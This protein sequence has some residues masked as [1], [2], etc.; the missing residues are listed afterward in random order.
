MSARRQRQPD[1]MML[2]LLWGALWGVALGMWLLAPRIVAEHHVRFESLDQRILFMLALAAMFAVLGGFLLLISGFVL[3]IIDSRFGPFVDRRWAYALGGAVLLVVVYALNSFLIYWITFRRLE[4]FWLPSRLLAAGKIVGIAVA[5][6]AIA[7][8]AAMR[9]YKWITG[10]PTL[11]ST[12]A[13]AFGLVGVAVVGAAVASTAGSDGSSSQPAETL[14]PI[15][16]QNDAPPLLFL[17]IDGASWRVLMPEMENGSAPTLRRLVDAGNSGTMEAL[18]PPH[19]SGAAWGAILTGLPREVTG[20]YEDLA[21]H[22]NGLPPFQIHL[23][24]NFLLNPVYSLR[25]FLSASG[26]IKPMLH[27]RSMLNGKPVWEWL[28][29]A[30]VDTAVVRFRFTFP[31]AGRANVAISDRVGFDGWERLGVPR[32]PIPEAVT[33]ADRADE[34]LAPFRTETPADA[35]LFDSLLPPQ[36]R[37]RPSDSLNDPIV[38][39]RTAADIDDRTFDATERI[40]QRNPTQPFLGVYIAGLDAVEHAFWQYRFP[41]DY[42]E[43]R[44]DAADIARL[45]EVLPRYLRYVDGRISRLLALYAQPPNVVIVSDHG[46]GPTTTSTDWRGWH[47]KEAIVIA[48]GP[49]VAKQEVPIRASYYDVLPTLLGLRGFERPASARGRSFVE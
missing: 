8:V 12:R 40:L 10:R 39:L 15:A 6:A 26:V 45:N 4:E 31:P 14:K 25:A 46:H 20:V 24:N 29:D 36:D 38:A 34:L 43:G 47:T 1:T 41:D 2:S 30:G 37:V 27:P 17:G 49:S 3:I 21:A 9:I 42:G 28:H 44:P 33:P 35:A 18:W 7:A 11:A 48:S 22:V 23:A 5:G 19:W 13:F 32:D 16:G